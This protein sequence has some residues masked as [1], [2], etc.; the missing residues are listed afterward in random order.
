MKQFIQKIFNSFGYKVKKVKSVD[1]TNLDD[2][3]LDDITK[4][5]IHKSE[6]V[7]FDVGAN[8]GQSITRYKKNFQKYTQINNN[9]N[10]YIY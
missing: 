8:K 10:K 3:N 7:I 4:L 6:P 9:S 2:T 1:D 5:L